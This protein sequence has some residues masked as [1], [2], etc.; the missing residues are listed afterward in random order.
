MSQPGLKSAHNKVSANPVQQMGLVLDHLVDALGGDP[1]CTL[2]RASILAD[3]D[4]HPGTTQSEVMDRL[5]L[6]KSALNRDIEW[7]YDHGCVLRQPG[8]Q[9]GRVI[10]MITCGYSKKNLGL[11]LDYFGNSHKKLQDFLESL[12]SMFTDHKPTLRDVKILASAADLGEAL[13]A[14]NFQPGV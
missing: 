11:A 5:K 8:Q 4:E 7:L 1:S 12:I 13:P 2:R 10:H 6:H 3:I 14:R 9:D